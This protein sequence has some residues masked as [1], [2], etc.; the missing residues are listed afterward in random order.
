[1]PGKFGRGQ[2]YPVIVVGA[3]GCGLV[4]ALAAAKSGARRVLVLE[5]GEKPGGNTALSTGLIPAAG[6]RFQREAGITD[7]TPE[8]MARDIMTK[9]SGQADPAIVTHLCQVSARLVEWLV[10]EVGCDLI[11]HTDFLYPGMSRLRMHGPPHGYGAEL[12]EQLQAAIDSDPRIELRTVTPVEALV[13]DESGCINGVR[14]A[15]QVVPA[16]AVVLASDGFGANPRMVR[17]HLGE[18]IASAPYSGC[19]NNTGDGIRW[20]I[21]VGAA[22]SCMDAYQGHGS[23]AAPDGPL[24]T[25]GLIVNGAVL[26]NREGSRFGDE[27]KGYSEFAQEVLSQPRGEAWEILDNQV[28]EAS[29]GTRFDEVIHAGRIISA[30][31]LDALASATGLPRMQLTQT[32]EEVRLVRRGVKPDR[33]GRSHFASALNTPPFHAIR[34]VGALFHTQGGLVVDNHARVLD[35]ARRPIRRLYAG[36]G[37]AVGISGRGAKGYLAGNGLLAALGLGLTAGCNA[38]EHAT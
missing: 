7:D 14:T 10:D 19:Q 38:A 24:V 11:C 5:K 18:Q 32:I 28:Y 25:W 22:T 34:V 6:T 36:G 37:T 27:S 26:V 12:I 4:A 20:G 30:S 35:K 9:N 2:E 16:Q 31:S 29:L 15:E 33:W 1:M 8:L 17:E 21:E 13:Q 3:G 23:V